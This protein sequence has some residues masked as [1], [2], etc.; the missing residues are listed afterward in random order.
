MEMEKLAEENRTQVGRGI[1]TRLYVG[2]ICYS[3]RER[4]NSQFRHK[5][6]TH[7]TI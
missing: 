1:I 6:Q 2:P 7:S 4:K 5:K 3:T